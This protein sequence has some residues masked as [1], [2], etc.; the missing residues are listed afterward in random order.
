MKKDFF[1]QLLSFYMIFG[2]SLPKK[3]F[4]VGYFYL[5]NTE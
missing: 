3:L 2:G 1:H 4:K 5:E